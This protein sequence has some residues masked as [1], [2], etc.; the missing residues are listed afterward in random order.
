M[1]GNCRT[2]L[3]ERAD[4]RRESAVLGSVVREQLMSRQH[5]GKF[6]DAGRHSTC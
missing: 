5:S 4:E 1:S 6:L 3:S 2:R